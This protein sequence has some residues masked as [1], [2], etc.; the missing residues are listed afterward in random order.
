MYILKNNVVPLQVLPY[1]SN[2]NLFNMPRKKRQPSIAELLTNVK[3]R[4]PELYPM[5]Y[6]E[7]KAIRD[8]ARYINI[9]ATRTLGDK[10]E[11]KNAEYRYKALMKKYNDALEL[12]R[13]NEEKW[14]EW[15][16]EQEQEERAIENTAIR[17]AEG[18]IM[19]TRPL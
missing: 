6:D 18:S 2:L 14:K 19:A 5:T 4:L 10:E 16:D 8:L 3:D 12:I 9:E 11:L 1:G 13:T 17:K 7:V 15:K